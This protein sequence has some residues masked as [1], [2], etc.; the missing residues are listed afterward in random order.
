MKWAIEIQKYSLE[1]RNIVDLLQGLGFEIVDGIDYKALYAPYFDS[2]ETAA[3]VWNE[4]KKI[5]DAFMAAAIDP[6]F[7]LGCVIDYSSDKLKRRGFLEPAS[8]IIETF[9]GSPTL[10]EIPPSNLSESELKEWEEKRAEADYQAKIERQ[11]EKLEPVFREPKASKILKALSEKDHTG[12][13]LYKTYEIMEGHPSNRKDFQLQF[14]ISNQE[15]KRFGDAVHNPV[16]SGDL[17]RHAYEDN[18][19]TDNPMTFQEAKNFIQVLAKKW[20]ASLRE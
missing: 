6:E 15:F 9:M 20:L 16:V 11:R 5:R 19:K 7:V 14:G 8:M 2:L 13:T 3:E 10:K 17:A 12:E 18:T 1:N 4:G